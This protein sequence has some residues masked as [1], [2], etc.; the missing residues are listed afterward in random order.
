MSPKHGYTVS[1]HPC[2][3]LLKIRFVIGGLP[4]ILKTIDYKEPDKTQ[5]GLYLILQLCTVPHVTLFKCRAIRTYTTSLL[6][7]HTC[8]AHLKS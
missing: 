6:T 1:K 3:V 4:V 7:A 8:D 5:V 2:K